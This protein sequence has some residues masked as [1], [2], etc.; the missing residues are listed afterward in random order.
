MHLEHE[1]QRK[2]ALHL[3]AAFDTRTGE[4]ARPVPTCVNMRGRTSIVACLAGA[5]T[6][7]TTDGHSRRSRFRGSTERSPEFAFADPR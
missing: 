1:Y 2:E 4:I 6:T 3:L 5:N 7:H